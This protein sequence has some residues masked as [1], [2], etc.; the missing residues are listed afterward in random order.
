ALALTDAHGREVKLDSARKRFRML[1]E[2]SVEE[3]LSN[4]TYERFSKNIHL[5]KGYLS[6][7]IV[8]E[9]ADI[10]FLLSLFVKY[11]IPEHDGGTSTIPQLPTKAEIK[12]DIRDYSNWKDAFINKRRT[13]Q[14][15]NNYN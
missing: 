6:S 12:Q 7:Y 8:I 3:V 4:K 1:I 5:Q 15:A 9:Q 11:S 14:I 2:R 13:F 10:D